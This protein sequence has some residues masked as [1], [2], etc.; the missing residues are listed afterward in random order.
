M[1][2]LVSRLADWW[3]ATQPD[4]SQAQLAARIAVAWPTTPA[5]RITQPGDREQAWATWVASVR[6]LLQ[7]RRLT[8]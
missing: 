8:D 7:Q 1:P 2:T 5:Y 6:V 4:S 3:T